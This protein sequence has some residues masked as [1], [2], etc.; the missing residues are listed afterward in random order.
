MKPNENLTRFIFIPTFRCQLKCSYCDYSWKVIEQDKEYQLEAFGHKWI[1]T[2]ELNW[3]YWLYALSRFRP[4]HLS[5]TGGEP[6]LWNGIVDFIEHIPRTCSWDI[7]SNTLIDWAIDKIL[8]VN[9]RTW[10]ASYHYH[11]TD[12]FLKN[13]KLLRVKGFPVTV[14]LVLRHDNIEKVKEAIALFSKSFIRTN[15]HPM[16][17]KGYSWDDYPDTLPALQEYVK[18]IDKEKL[19]KIIWQIRKTF[20]P[21]GAKEKCAAGMNFFTLFPDGSA[22]R[23]YSHA[24][25]AGKPPLGKI[26]EVNKT[27]SKTPCDGGCIFPCDIDCQNDEHLKL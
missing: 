22:W 21:D 12:D 8:P 20:E 4:Y 1:I 11:H 23:C 15:I 26:W 2:E 9:I 16:L 17:K 5:F 6:T 27:E 24:L 25:N 10:T 18:T 7:T 3:A 13:I 19:V 14:T